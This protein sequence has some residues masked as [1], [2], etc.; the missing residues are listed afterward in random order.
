MPF[1]SSVRGSFGLK[2]NPFPNFTPNTTN[3]VIT[4]G[5]ISTVGGL[6]LHTYTAGAGQT[7][8]VTPNESKNGTNTFFSVEYLLIGGGGG[9]SGASPNQGIGGGGG[10]GGVI[11]SASANIGQGTFPITVGSAGSLGS[12]QGA[13]SAGGNTTAF[14]LTAYGGG[15]GANHWNAGGSASGLTASTGSPPPGGN[16]GSGGGGGNNG[17]GGLGGSGV[18]GQGNPGGQ[19]SAYNPAPSPTGGGGG[20]GYSGAGANGL[21]NGGNPAGGNGGSGVVIIAYPDTFP[22]LTTIPGTLTYDQPTRSG[23]RVYRFTA[24][25]GTVTF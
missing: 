25:S 1:V 16:G 3:S 4:G 2:R 14:D 18:G 11:Y 19:S 15:G 17:G 9:G 6:R 24:G 7:F 13:G 5:S 21:S 20:G 8:S 12:S 22:A 10:G 23:Y